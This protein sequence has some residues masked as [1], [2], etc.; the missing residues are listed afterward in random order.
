MNE[1]W[2]YNQHLNCRE[3]K[4]NVDCSA[5]NTCKKYFFHF[6][7][8]TADDIQICNIFTQKRQ[9]RERAIMIICI[10]SVTNLHKKID[11][12]QLQCIYVYCYNLIESILPQK[13]DE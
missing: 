13:T 12:G 8:I 3:A 2:W 5:H 9:F 1:N 10:D 6:L 11:K 4:E 7:I